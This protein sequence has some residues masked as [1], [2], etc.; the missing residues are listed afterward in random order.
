MNKT[1]LLK[2]TLLALLVMMTFAALP[3][4]AQ[5]VNQLP[6]DRVILFC[7]STTLDV[8]GATD[9]G[10]GVYLTSFFYGDLVASGALT[11]LT[12]NG[13][14]TAH[15]DLRGNIYVQWIGGPYYAS[16][17]GDFAKRIVCP[18]LITVY[19][20]LLR[21]APPSYGVPT[22]GAPTYGAP[23]YGAPIG[24]VNPE[25]SYGTPNQTSTG[26]QQIAIIQQSP[27]A[28]INQSVGVNAPA[29]A[30]GSRVYVVQ[31]G[32]TLYRISRRFGTTVSAL[33]ACNS[34]ANPTRIYIGQQ[35]VVP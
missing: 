19:S 29:S 35:I 6:G 2:L 21:A 28:V 1:R 30:C 11:R 23:S 31:Q 20:D 27:G 3:V 5:G 16:G 14:V 17:T 8:Y 24:G 13:Q 32:D 22:Y 33:S 25:Y 12:G 7:Q 9:M 15:A 34:I 26:I 10:T 4:S 18:G